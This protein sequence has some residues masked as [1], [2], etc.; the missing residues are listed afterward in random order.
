MTNKLIRSYLVAGLLLWA[1]TVSAEEGK[2][3]PG[4]IKLLPAETKL[5][6]KG[7]SHSLVV[8]Q[9]S[10]DQGT[11]DLTARAKFASSND[12]IATVDE[13]GTIR[14]AGDGEATITA[15]VEGQKVMAAV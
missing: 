1:A 4:S 13:K 10:S 3:A 7:E 8:E 11:G 15:D 5:T 6:Y 9:M 14:A 12:A 2:K